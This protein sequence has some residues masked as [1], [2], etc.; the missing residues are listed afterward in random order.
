MKLNKIIF[1][2][3]RSSYTPNQ[4]LGELLYIPRDCLKLPDK[5]NKN[6][7]S[8]NSVKES[9][10]STKASSKPS[11]SNRSKHIP[12]L[13]LPYTSGSSKLLIYFHGNA[14]DIGLSYE[15]LDHLKS[16]LKIN[17]LA[18]EFPGY[19]IYND[20]G[21]CSAEKITEDSDYV[22]QYVL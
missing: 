6:T 11:N 8:G 10:A 7:N 19:G 16:S 2:A 9:S 13:F 21:G 15:M 12:C 5:E 14:E 3:P 20:A 1:P 22:F 18:V 4:L 17:I